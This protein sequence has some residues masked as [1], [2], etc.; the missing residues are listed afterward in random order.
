MTKKTTNLCIAIKALIFILAVGLSHSYAVEPADSIVISQGLEELSVIAFGTRKMFSTAPDGSISISARHLSDLPSFM[1]GNDPMFL[2]RSLP[3]LGTANELSPAISVRGGKSAGNLFESDGIRIINPMHMLGLYSAFNSVFYDTFNFNPGYASVNAPNLTG[4]LFS[5]HSMNLSPDTLLSATAALGLIESHGAIRTPLKKGVTSFAIG[6]RTS[7]LNLLFPSVLKAGSSTIKYSFSDLNANFIWQPNIYNLLRFSFFYNIDHMNVDNRKNG[8]KE[9]MGG[10]HNLA[11]GLEWLHRGWA[12]KTTL[13][14]FY[15]IFQLS[16]GGRDIDLPSSF[17]QASISG[18]V[19]IGNFQLSSELCYRY[20]GGQ[21]R[22]YESDLLPGESHARELNIT[23]EWS[24]NI[25]QSLDLTIGIKMTVYH[26]GKYNTL[27]PLPRLKGL[28][29]LTPYLNLYGAYGRYTRFDHIVEETTNGLPADFYI[30]ANEKIKPEDLNSFEIGF[31]G[32]V[33]YINLEYD[34]TGYYK[35]IANTSEYAGSLLNLVNNDYNPLD[36][37]MN[38]HGYATGL[39]A[40]IMRQWGKIRGRVSYNLGKS[41]LKFARYGNQFFPSA[42]DRL[43]D[44]NLSLSWTVTKGLTLN[45]SFVHATGTPFTRAKYGYMIGENLI[46]EY[47]PHNS[48]RLPA[49]NRADLSATWILPFH[50]KGKHSLNVSIYNVLANKNVLFSF[51]TY[52]PDK[53][54]RQKESVMK[55]IIPS[56]T[57]IFEL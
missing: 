3:A 45:G 38:G 39:S 33:P 51:S 55:T 28:W 40:S 12:I 44:L 2:L 56:L 4:G 34:L 19:P 8:T 48:S 41:R 23:G 29:T 32:M 42:H 22:K 43:H 14:T 35:L 10:W 50:T 27:R 36:D 53:G 30:N 21:G 5:A 1:G 31:R 57:Y 20:A 6:A 54:I 9:G 13:S 47:Y 24:K 37:V 16:E 15:N 52:S 26:C 7:Y 18:T 46:C 17:T 11:T 25:A 49:Y